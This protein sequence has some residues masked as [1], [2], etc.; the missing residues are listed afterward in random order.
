MLK[1]W[2][3]DRIRLNKDQDENSKGS[4]SIVELTLNMWSIQFLPVQY[5][6]YKMV[7]SRQ[8]HVAN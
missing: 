7:C 8:R 3:P 6:A 4:S 5:N 1:C 2:V